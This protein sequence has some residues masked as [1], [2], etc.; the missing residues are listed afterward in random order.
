MA[1]DYY[2]TMP[3][4]EGLMTDTIKTIQEKIKQATK[5]QKK[6]EQS[7]DIIEIHADDRPEFWEVR[8]YHNDAE[9]WR[10]GRYSVNY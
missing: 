6:L 3:I 1:Q 5:E 2:F 10:E 9:P 7:P 4:R 8:G